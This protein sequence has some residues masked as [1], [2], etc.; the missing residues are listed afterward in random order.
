MI[1]AYQGAIM[2]LVAFVVTFLM[3]PVSKKIAVVIGA[4]D[5]PG[6]RRMNT[7]PIPRCGGIALY[8]GLVAACFVMYLGI[9]F[10]GWEAVDLYV[11]KEVNYILLF[12]GVTAMFTVGLVD[13]ITQLTPRVKLIGQIASAIIVVAAGISITTVRTVVGDAFVDLG[14]IDYP[15]TVIYLVA[16]VNI[17]NLIDGLDGLA[18]GIVAIISLSLLYMVLMRGSFTFAML[19]IAIIAVCLAFLRYNFPPASIFMGDSGSH[20]L[21]LVVGIVA[22]SGIVRAQNLLVLLVP[23]IIAGVPVLDTL[24]AIIRRLRGHKPVQE[25]DMD[26]IHHRLLK[27][28]LG[29]RRSVFVLYLCSALLAL[30]GVLISTLT[31]PA[32]WVILISLAVILFIVIWRFGLFKPV[33][34]HYYD[35]KGRRGPRQNPKEKSKNDRA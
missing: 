14:W 30:V 7:E 34:K 31:G 19:C 3:V 21:G 18:A 2:F 23:V 15:L 12:V 6:N 24:S 22:I 35:N 20:L 26:H 10:F 29:P 32:Q 17:I 11:L 13:D 28:G 5:Y 33:L 16:F 1:E 25:S 9:R 8:S 27:A 4:I